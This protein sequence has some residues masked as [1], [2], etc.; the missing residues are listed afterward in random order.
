MPQR[1]S[2]FYRTRDVVEILGISRR[3]LQYWAQTDLVTPSDKTPGGHRRYC[4][5]DLVALK[6]T[7]RLIDAGISVQR[8]RKSIQ[9]LRKTLPDIE[10]PLSELVLVATGDVVLAFREGAAFEAISGQE[11]VFEVAEFEREVS[12]W[13]GTGLAQPIRRPRKVESRTGRLRGT[14]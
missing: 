3:Q 10:R 9:A 6:A 13:R 14:G 1:S 8:V 4:F 7:K 2:P 12:D 5:A 11:W